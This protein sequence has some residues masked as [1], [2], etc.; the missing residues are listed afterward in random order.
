MDLDNT[1]DKRKMISI[2]L[3]RISLVRFQIEEFR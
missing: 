2:L 1:F 3:I